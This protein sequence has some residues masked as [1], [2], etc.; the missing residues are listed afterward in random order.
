[1]LTANELLVIQ[2]LGKQLLAVAI[3]ITKNLNWERPPTIV[4]LYRCHFIGSP[5]D[6]ASKCCIFLWRLDGTLLPLALGLSIQIILA[7]D[8]KASVD[9]CGS[10]MSHPAWH[11]RNYHRSAALWDHREEL[12]VPLAT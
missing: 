7:M 10:W 6:A 9:F 2:I 11:I 1:M 5:W 3:L 4:W 8:T 12:Y